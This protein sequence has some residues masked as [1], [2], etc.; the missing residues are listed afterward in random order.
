MS[1][2]LE[3]GVLTLEQKPFIIDE[4]TCISTSRERNNCPVEWHNHGK[5]CSATCQTKD[6]RTFGAC[7]RSKRLNLAPNLSDTNTQKQWD[8]ELDAYESARRQGV[9]P[10]GT[11][12]QKVDQAMREAEAAA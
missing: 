2:K 12:M 3:N 6:H 9:E 5:N 4:E 1:V 11:T 8:K 10:E 7:M